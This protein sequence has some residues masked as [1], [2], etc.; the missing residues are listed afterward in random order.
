[1]VGSAIH[2]R[3]FDPAGPGLLDRFASS[4]F[5]YLFHHAFLEGTVRGRFTLPLKRLR[6]RE[7]PRSGRNVWSD[8]VGVNYY[9]REIVQFGLNGELLVG[10]RIDRPGVPRNDLG[11]EIYPKGLERVVSGAYARYHL[12]I[13]VTEN[14]TCDRE[15]R[16]R[17]RFL[18]DHLAAVKRIIDGGVDL[19]RYYHWTLL[20][21]FEWA[22]GLSARFGLVEVDFATQERRIRPSGRFFARVAADRG[23]RAECLDRFGRQL[24]Y[25]GSG[26]R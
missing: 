8:F 5:T 22:E 10:R 1:M 18:Y 23:V 19:R 14:G 3:V 4:T 6:F 24:R 17:A 25:R 2:F 15:D 26:K 12:P 11:W 21:N 20:D 7:L 9:S 16:F 13:Y